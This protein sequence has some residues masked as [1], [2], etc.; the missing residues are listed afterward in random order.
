MKKK[1][2][3]N[4]QQQQQLEKGIQTS[5]IHFWNLKLAPIDSALNSAS[6]NLTQKCRRGTKNSSQ[7][8]FY[9][10]CQIFILTL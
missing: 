5:A 9:K 10:L 6:G 8:Y 4:K 2:P 1:K 3:N 7:T